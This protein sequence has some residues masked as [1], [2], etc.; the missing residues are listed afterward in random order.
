MYYTLKKNKSFKMK[1]LK[2]INF[3][4]NNI[5]RIEFKHYN[6]IYK[7]YSLYKK[8]HNIII[9]RFLLNRYLKNFRG[10]KSHQDIIKNLIIKIELDYINYVNWYKKMKNINT[11]FINT[12]E[13]K[14]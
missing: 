10:V 14:K 5:N 12:I 8:N 13:K 1:P 6:I 2:N 11:S 4:E 9:L 3:N 7:K